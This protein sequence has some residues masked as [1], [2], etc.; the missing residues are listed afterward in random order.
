MTV[1]ERRD[2]EITELRGRVRYLSERVR[3]LERELAATEPVVAAVRRARM[4]DFVPY[5]ATPDPDWVAIDRQ[6]A[7]NLLRALAGT[8]HWRPWTTVIERRGAT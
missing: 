5:E 1:P 3:Q 8:D 6:D 7:Q 4:W 2:H